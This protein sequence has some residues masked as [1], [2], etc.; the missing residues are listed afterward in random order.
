MR[1]YL[2]KKIIIDLNHETSRKDSNQRHK[3]KMD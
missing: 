3:R 2:P 1:G